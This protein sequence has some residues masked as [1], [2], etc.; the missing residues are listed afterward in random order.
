MTIASLPIWPFEP[1]WATNVTETLEWLTD[2][3]A[4]PTGSEQR[5]SLRLFPRASY[6]FAI[7]A[8]GDERTLLDN[9]LVSYGSA[10]WHFPVWFDA[11]FLS[12][13][14]A[15][16]ASTIPCATAQ[17]GQFVVGGVAVLIGD[18]VYTN[19]LVEIESIGG[20]AL[21]LSDPVEGAWPIGTRLHPVVKG[22]L[23]DQPTIT[24]RNDQ[25]AVSQIKFRR[26]DIT[27]DPGGDIGSDFDESYDGFFVMPFAPDETKDLTSDYERILETLDNQTSIPRQVDIPGRAFTVQQYSWVLEGRE[28]HSDFRQMLLTLRGRATSIWLPTFMSDFTLLEPIASGDTSIVTT[29]SG[30]VQTGG[31][32]PDREHIMIETVGGVRY[33]R[34]IT[35]AA[36]DSD[37][38]EILAL[39]AALGANVA[40]NAVLRISFMTLV[41]LNQDNIQI[42][43]NTDIEGVSVVQAAFRSAPDTRTSSSAFGD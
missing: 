5:R 20:S 31:P 4:S 15:V 12:A 11:H 24:K 26:V 3:M 6:E 34:Q 10:D 43:H 27:A 28:Q 21:T 19:E 14:I 39:N 23:T 9:L 40:I 30:F 42:E 41:R 37:G 7:A 22:R 33:Y 8:Q 1:N 29:R 35:D 18:D 2:V 16:G 36:S 38:N 32:R 17:L 13:G 25:L